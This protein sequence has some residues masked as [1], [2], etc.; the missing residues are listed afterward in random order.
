MFREPFAPDEWYHCYSRGVDKRK[1][2]ET[3][4]DYQRFIQTLYLCNSIVPIHQD[5]LRGYSHV[6]ILGYPRDKNLVRIAT[7]C[8]MPN[9]FH[10]LLQENTKAGITRFMRKV[11]TAYTM[12]FNIKNNRTGNLFIKPF[13]S[14]RVG[15]ENYLK[16]LPH[17]LHLNPAD[18]FEPGWKSGRIQNIKTLKKKLVEYS[19]S[20]LSDYCGTNRPE[21]KILSE[22]AMCLFADDSPPTKFI[23]DA[24]AYYQELR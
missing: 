24:A 17:Y 22:S 20:S 21:R 10:L 19:Y 13:R 23:S 3:S 4:R 5:D 14:K 8:L 6:D 12:Y 9:H 1:V 2:F 15:N 16:H 18:I 11:G 7:Y